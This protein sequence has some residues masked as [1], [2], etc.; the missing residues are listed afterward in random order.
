MIIAMEDYENLLNEALKNV[1]TS[2]EECARVE[3]KK[4]EGHVEGSKTIITNFLQVADCLR[5]NSAH[6]AKFLFKELATPGEISGDRLILVRKIPSQRINDKIQEYANKF[7]IC[8]NC[9]KPDTELV[10]QDGQKY[11]RCL[12][13]GNRKIIAE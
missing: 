10:E 13:C 12:A 6:L 8:P 7:V 3:I 9:K 4:V 2:C 11:L 5:R 1:K